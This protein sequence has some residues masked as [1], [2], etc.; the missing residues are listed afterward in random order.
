M[1]CNSALQ[2]TLSSGNLC[3]CATG[4][5]N[6]S[7]VCLACNYVC[8]TCA[9]ASTCLTCK[10]GLNRIYNSA[11]SSCDCQSGYILNVSSNLCLGCQY[12]C[13]VCVTNYTNQCSSCNAS[14][15]RTL[16][17]TTKQ[18]SCNIG[19]YDNNAALCLACSYTC[20]TCSVSS[21]NCTACT[22]GSNRNLNSVAGT[23]SCAQ[24]YYDTIVIF[25]PNVACA[26]CSYFCSSCTNSSACLTC[27]STNKRTFDSLGVNCI[28]AQGYYDDNSSRELCVACPYQCLSCSNSSVCLTCNNSNNRATPTSLCPCIVGYYDTNLTAQLCAACQYSC[29]ACTVFTRCDSC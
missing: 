25:A 15:Y 10:S 29:K 5:Y 17:T 18:C 13:Q 12:S 28:C 21:T 16:N 2:L 19:Y 26:A 14:Y 27:N 24:H 23:C 8:Q 1:S 11:T 20:Y 7:N 6:A 22:T 9:A 4:Y 3:V